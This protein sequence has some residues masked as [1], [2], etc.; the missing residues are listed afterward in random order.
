MMDS[1]S[2]ARTSQDRRRLGLGSPVAS[3]SCLRRD[4]PDGGHLAT[5]E[6][7]RTRGPPAEAT[8]RARRMVWLAAVLVLLWE[9]GVKSRANNLDLCIRSENGHQVFVQFLDPGSGVDKSKSPPNPFPL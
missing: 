9:R 8:S 2:S 4:K 7:C 3:Q 5:K 1:L 6:M